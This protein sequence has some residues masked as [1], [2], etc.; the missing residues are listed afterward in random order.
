M[1]RSYVVGKS[2]NFCKKNGQF[3]DLWKFAR[4]FELRGFIPSKTRFSA[5]MDQILMLKELKLYFTEKSCLS[6]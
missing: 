1:V 6:V 5:H 2:C 3:L 4:P